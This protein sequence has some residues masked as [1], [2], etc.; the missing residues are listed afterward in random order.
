[1][2]I[3]HAVLLKIADSRESPPRP[4]LSP[5]PGSSGVLQIRF[6]FA[7]LAVMA[8]HG[9]DVAP[10]E[11]QQGRRSPPPRRASGGLQ[12]AWPNHAA[13][14]PAPPSGSATVSPSHFTAV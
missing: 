10:L 3:A 6:R 9:L 11:V 1:M 4:P 13:E 12:P 2:P 8:A 7:G 14:N 5:P